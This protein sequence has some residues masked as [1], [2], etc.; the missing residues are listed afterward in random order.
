MIR[1][2]AFR[3][4]ISN[5]LTCYKIETNLAIF[6]KLMFSIQCLHA[7]FSELHDNFKI[8]VVEVPEFEYVRFSKIKM[9]DQV[10][11]FPIG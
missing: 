6:T 10:P 2:R 3:G 9:V 8:M 1:V 7:I 4:T 11:V 5:D